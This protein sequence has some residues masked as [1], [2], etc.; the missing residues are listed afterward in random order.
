MVELNRLF[1]KVQFLAGAPEG[2]AVRLFIFQSLSF[3]ID[4]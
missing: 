1:L 4:Y 2:G 3:I